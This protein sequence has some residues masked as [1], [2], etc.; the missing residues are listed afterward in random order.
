MQPY[1]YSSQ[2]QAPSILDS[3][4]KGLNIGLAIDN[5]HLAKQ[6]KE[7]Q[8]QQSQ[9]TM[10]SEQRRQ[11]IIAEFSAKP[12]PS[13]SDYARLITADP[14]NS[15]AFK[16]AADITS[17]EQRDNAFSV[18]SQ[19]FA[20]ANVGNMN[21]ANSLIDKQ[22]EAATNTGDKKQ[23]QYFQTVKQLAN[24]DPKLAKMALASAMHGIDPQKAQTVIDSANKMALAPSE[25][26]KA[27]ALATSAEATAEVDKGTIQTKIK[28]AESDLEKSGWA[29]KDIK[30]QINTRGAQLGLD[31]QRLELDTK[32]KLGELALQMGK[33]E[34][35][36][37]K[38]VN[39]AVTNAVASKQ[40]SDQFNSLATRLE[41]TKAF[42]GATATAG[43]WLKKVGGVQDGITG[44]RQEYI[45]LRQGAVSKSLPPGPASD[46]DI[47]L[48]L[49]GFP[50]D[51]ANPKL[52]ASFLR[53]MAKIGD[54][55]SSVDNAKAEW[56]AKN[57]GQLSR[58]TS[59]FIAG[60]Y[61]A[62]PGETFKD[63]SDRVVQDVSKKYEPKRPLAEGIP[64]N[65]NY[66][67]PQSQPT[68][69]VRSQADAILSGRK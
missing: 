47:Q 37:K 30:S 8:I 60:D 39:D 10:E 44:L 21:V 49:S 36:T 67:D 17:Q 58:A 64:G 7:L 9:Q 57:N 26:R 68:Q 69:D 27:E 34:P 40:S 22:I 1:D 12:N 52:M 11:Q 24:Y 28:Q 18:A 35:E 20:A 31:R 6:Q 16:R 14:K 19:L 46:K 41:Q 56:L 3:Y 5:A 45:R 42:S 43:E 63:F 61:A 23:L 2:L 51:T 4:G 50:S 55:Q 38:M 53:G 65:P 48:A 33:V 25:L 15:E 54:V 62:R 29:I 13:G 59:T 66:I 32:V